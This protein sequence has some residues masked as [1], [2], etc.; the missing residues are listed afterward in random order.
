MGYKVLKKNTS[1]TIHQFFVIGL[2][3]IL[4][5]CSSSNE[6]T[7]D[8]CNLA[9]YDSNE[10]CQALFNEPDRLY[11][12]GDAIFS[13]SFQSRS[14]LEAK[15]QANSNIG[16]KVAEISDQLKTV[17][18]EI[19]SKKEDGTVTKTT[20]TKTEFDIDI[21]SVKLEFQHCNNAEKKCYVAV[22]VT[23]ED[24]KSG[25]VS[26]LRNEGIYDMLV[27]EKAYQEFIASL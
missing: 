20:I 1:F 18:V 16:R 22:S 26:D 7:Y 4:M 24:I 2:F 25:I 10:A 9:E 23:K 13:S 12:I 19:I 21:P 5:G 14:L 3:L 8:Q 17:V 15:H 6:L 11:A 27:N